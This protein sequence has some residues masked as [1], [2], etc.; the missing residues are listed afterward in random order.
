MI[1][2]SILLGIYNVTSKRLLAGTGAELALLAVNWTAAGALQFLAASI[3]GFPSLGEGFW[4]AV[5]ISVALNVLCQ[6]LLYR[7]IAA[8]DVSF[9]SPMRLLTPLLVFGTAFI[10]LGEIPSAWGV[11]G[12][13]CSLAGLWFL[14]SSHA[15]E[16]MRSLRQLISSK[17][18]IY[19]LIAVTLFSV[20]FVFDK[21]AVLASSALFFSALSF[22]FTGIICL[23]IYFAH[24]KN[25][26]NSF[27][28]RRFPPKILIL[29]ILA[30][31]VAGVLV[32]HALNFA[33][34]AYASSVK[35]LESLWTVLFAGAFLREG[36]IPRKIVACLVMLA[37]VAMTVFLG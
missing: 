17:P 13:V 35:R 10:V 34:A 33:P 24:R 2:G 25:T 14:L 4:P 19:A 27:S 20:S 16:S 6:F 23:C 28:I 8:N 36:N 18:F 26:G 22:F 29:N 21:R 30:L 37:G 7:A 31:A 9:I 11:A 12:V 1:P 15:G 32:T 3:V 5:W